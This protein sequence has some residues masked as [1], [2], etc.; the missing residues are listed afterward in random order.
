MAAF[1][2]QFSITDPLNL[3]VV[4]QFFGWPYQISREAADLLDGRSIGWAKSIASQLERVIATAA[5]SSDLPLL[6]PKQSKAHITRTV[7]K[8]KNISREAY[9]DVNIFA[10]YEIDHDWNSEAVHSE[11][12]ERYAVLALWKIV[13]AYIALDDKP[14][15][16]GEFAM[17]AQEIASW[18]AA[19]GHALEA[20][21]ALQ[22]A[23]TMLMEIAAASKRS[24]HSNSVKT[25]RAKKNKDAALTMANSMYFKDIEDAAEYV[26][27]RIV[28]SEDSKGYKSTYTE[29]YMVKILQAGGWR[30]WKSPDSRD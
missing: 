23:R 7:L 2:N 10:A 15:P 29:G 21:R 18:N 28:K 4:P 22:T 24:K 25:D 1:T 13:D 19:G 20:M 9:G 14:I 26:A 5:N 17:A 3:P 12:W 8:L 30:P 27:A 6:G 11:R 16:N